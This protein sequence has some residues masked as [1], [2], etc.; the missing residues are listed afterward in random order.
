MKGY[1][2]TG[3][4]LRDGRP[5]PPIGEWL[6]HE[7]SVKMCRYGLHASPTAFAALQC[8]AND[9]ALSI[10]KL[11]RPDQEAPDSQ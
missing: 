6:I 1:H 10:K 7:G 11:E 4:T 8:E 3:K 2:F 5:I 9:R